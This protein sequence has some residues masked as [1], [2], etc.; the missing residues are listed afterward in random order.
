[1]NRVTRTRSAGIIYSRTISL[2]TLC[3]WRLYVSRGG[4]RPTIGFWSADFDVYRRLTHCLRHRIFAQEPPS[5]RRLSVG[6][7]TVFQKI[8]ERSRRAT[9][10]N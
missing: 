8:S 9:V 4:T 5:V 6:V 7:V 3:P 2:C 10:Y 1:M